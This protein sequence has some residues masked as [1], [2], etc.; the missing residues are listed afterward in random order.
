MQGK[1]YP[2]VSR[3]ELLDQMSNMRTRFT[4]YK[5]YA[6][7]TLNDIFTAEELK[8]AG[9]LS[10]D[11]LQTAV[12]ESSASGKLIPK[13]LPL[14]A[15]Y[16]PVYSIAIIDFDKDGSDDLLMCGNIHQARLRFGKN[17]ANYGV[18]LK[19]DGKGSFTYISQSQSGFSLKGDVRSVQQVN[20]KLIFGINNQPLKAYKLTRADRQKQADLLS[21]K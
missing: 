3:D 10:A 20:D 2:Y 18:L 14:Q 15:Q 17:D 12:F 1:S 19:G 21:K 8:G 9:H 4:D 6:D 16:A 13:D 7:A 11:Y 5:S